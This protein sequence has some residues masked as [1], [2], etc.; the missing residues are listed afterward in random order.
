MSVS[1]ADLYVDGPAA[2]AKAKILLAHFDGA[3]DAEA[4]ERIVI[5]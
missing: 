1:A 3:I 4:T 5:G 2:D